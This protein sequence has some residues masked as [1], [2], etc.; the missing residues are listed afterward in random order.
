[1]GKRAVGH[2]QHDLQKELASLPDD[3]EGIF[4]K[5]FDFQEIRPQLESLVAD[6]ANQNAPTDELMSCI[7]E[8][9]LNTSGRYLK[10]TKPTHFQPLLKQRQ[11][12]WR[13]KRKATQG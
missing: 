4:D 7:A 9:F 11:N 13:G 10:P 1:M 5:L 2:F 12:S 3:P 8:Q 6:P